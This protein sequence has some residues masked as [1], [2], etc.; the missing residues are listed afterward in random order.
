MSNQVHHLTDM[1]LFLIVLVAYI[2][3]LLTGIFIGS[4]S[5]RKKN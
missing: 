3:A 2:G 1:Q 5:N 4:T